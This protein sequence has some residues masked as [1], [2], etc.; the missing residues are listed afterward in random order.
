MSSPGNSRNSPTGAGLAPVEVT[1]VAN[2]LIY[3]EL[4]TAVRTQLSSGPARRAI[5]TAGLAATSGALTRAFAASRRADGTYRQDNLFR[6]LVV[7][8]E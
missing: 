5:D 3:P 6:F 1:D 8:V 4:P 7:S 2:P